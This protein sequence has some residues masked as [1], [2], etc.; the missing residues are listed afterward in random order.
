MMDVRISLTS[1]H[2]N[3]AY[4]VINSAP[5]L[6]SS[7]K[8]HGVIFPLSCGIIGIMRKFLKRTFQCCLIV[9][10]I[11]IV[12]IPVTAG[13]IYYWYNN[14]PQPDPIANQELFQGITYTRD[15]RTLPRPVVIHVATIDLNANGIEFLVT[16]PDDIDGFDY[17]ARTASEFLDEFDVQ[18]AINTDKFNP[19]E[20]INPIDFYPHSGDGVNV[21][22]LTI[23]SGEVVSE[24]YRPT[25]RTLFINQN[26]DAWI[27][28]G[29]RDAYNATSGLGFGSL[30]VDGEHIPADD[31]VSQ[32]NKLEPR[33]AVALDESATT[34]MF[35]IV[36]GR[37]PNYS[38]G[39]TPSELAQIVL[40][41]GGYN[42]M[43]FDGGGS[44]TMVIEGDNGSPD[45]L[46]SPIHTGIPGR[47]RPVAVHLG[48]YAQPR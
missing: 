5:F 41:Y 36:D 1:P 11:V 48:V 17:R 27:S 44:A 25:P 38:E 9:I 42:A 10:L 39:V 14:R 45:V 22:G 35:F 47:Q 19:W 12:A 21:Q 23:S 15:V 3:L 24:G 29:R 6:R 34:M 16:P 40:E 7:R 37:Q 13:G 20:H 31:L 32:L 18:L 8:I 43:Q 33:I 30:L 28:G 26:N 4:L 46:N 2:S